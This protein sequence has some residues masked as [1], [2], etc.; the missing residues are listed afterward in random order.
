[1]PMTRRDFLK[2]SSLAAAGGLITATTAALFNDE[3]NTLSIEHIT[4]PIPNL[5]PALEGFKIVQMSDI[6]LYP[7]TKLELVQRAVQVSNS[8]KP[9]IT[10][11]TGDYV[12]RNLSAINDLTPALAELDAKYGV[13]ATMGNH[14]Y[15]LNVEVIKESFKSV[16]LPV[17]ENQGVTFSVDG[18]PLHLAGLDDGW[19]GNPDLEVAMQ[20]APE[21]APV[22][23]LMHEPDLADIY[24]QDPRISL[25]LSGHTHGGQIRIPGIGALVHPHLGKKYDFGLYNVNGMWLY[26]NRGIGCISEPIR[27]NCPPE[28]SEFTLARA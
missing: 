11:L 4:I 27:L 6:H 13:F 9:D 16:G 17:L 23:L 12:W 19:S 10:V 14:D 1:M 20:G 8:L 22:V 26:T 2:F 15:W 7:F 3:S 21:G 28:I 25:Q 5:Q 24:S 18:A